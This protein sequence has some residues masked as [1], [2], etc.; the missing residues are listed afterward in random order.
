VTQTA[1]DAIDA[2]AALADRGG[3][4]PE[5]AARIDKTFPL[6]DGR[7]TERAYE[8]I[9]RLR[10]PMPHEEALRPVAGNPQT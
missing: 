8:A 10:R 3:P 4:E 6:R 5:Y 7:C 9:L 1:D 2:L